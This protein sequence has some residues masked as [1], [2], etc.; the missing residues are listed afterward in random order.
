MLVN[1]AI[2]E[3]CPPDGEV[4]E[5][6]EEEGDDKGHTEEELPGMDEVLV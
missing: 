2:P 6:Y 5:P 3:S 4:A 1:T